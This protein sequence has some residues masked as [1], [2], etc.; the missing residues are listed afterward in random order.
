MPLPDIAAD[1]GHPYP[2]TDSRLGHVGSFHRDAPYDFIFVTG[3][4]A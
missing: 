1:A 3:E 2:E 4:A